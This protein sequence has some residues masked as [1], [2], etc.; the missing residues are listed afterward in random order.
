MLMLIPQSLAYALLADLPPQEGL[1]ASMLPL[2]AYALFG[3]SRTLAIG[4]AA[5]TSLMTGAA[6]GQVAAAG[7]AASWEVALVL[8][9]LSGL[10]LTAMGVLRLGLLANYLSH[11]VISGFIS[12]SGVLIAFGQ[13]KHVLGV[14]A[15][16]DTL[17][18]LLPALWRSLPHTHVPTL[19]LG[20]VA[21]VF[22]WWSPSR[23]KPWLR[24][25]GVGSSMADALSKAGPVAAV[26]ATCAPVRC[27]RYGAALR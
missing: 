15:S 4:P 22:L 17:P 16:G 26:T 14:T 25:Q 2:L 10:M 27:F 23:L 19:L 1:Y 9:L 20:L 21:L 6:I 3:S 11:P 24:R 5:V 18:E 13:A 8:A 7:S 12:A